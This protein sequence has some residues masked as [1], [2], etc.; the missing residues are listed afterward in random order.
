MHLVFV[1]VMFV[2]AARLSSAAEDVAMDFEAKV[3]KNAHVTAVKFYSSMCGSCKDFAP[4][5]DDFE[6]AMQ[7][8]LAFGVVDIDKPAGMKLA[9]DMG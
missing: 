1:L 3:L 4:I 7:G 5:W 2:A 8:H 6:S 9:A